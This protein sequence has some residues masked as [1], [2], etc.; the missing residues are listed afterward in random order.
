TQGVINADYLRLGGKTVE[1]TFLPSSPAMVSKDL[2]ESHP[3]K[4]VA[5][6]YQK[7]DEDK[8][9]PGTLSGLGANAYDAWLIIQNAAAVA[10]KAAKPGTREFRKALRDSIEGG[11]DVKATGGLVN[12]SADDH[13]GFSMDA[14]V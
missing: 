13:F 9:G 10:E 7:L 8:Y 3:A 14:P 11:K 5:V 1:G 6:T 12:M 2:P 4:A